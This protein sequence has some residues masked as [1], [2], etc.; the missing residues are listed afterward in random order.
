MWRIRI[1]FCTRGSCLWGIYIRQ[2]HGWLRLA[3]GLNGL[4]WDSCN[5]LM[6]GLIAPS[7]LRFTSESELIV[8]RLKKQMKDKCYFFYHSFQLH[9]WIFVD[10][11]GSCFYIVLGTFHTARW[12]IVRNTYTPCLSMYCSSTMPHCSDWLKLAIFFFFFPAMN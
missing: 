2:N 3:C 5:N 8:R 11:Q 12:M 4:C 6:S 10:H 1:L 7:Y 9:F